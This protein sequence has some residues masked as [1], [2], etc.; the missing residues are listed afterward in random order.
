MSSG[1]L[2]SFLNIFFI[3]ESMDTVL[4]NRIVEISSEIVSGVYA[5]KTEKNII[6]EARRDR[7]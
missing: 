6:G 4:I 7:Q 1:D 5:S 3:N 2:F